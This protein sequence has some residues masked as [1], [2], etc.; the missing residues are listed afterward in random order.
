MYSRWLV[1]QLL[2]SCFDHFLLLYQKDVVKNVAAYKKAV[3]ISCMDPK[4]NRLQRKS[5]IEG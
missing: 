1:V 4:N 3:F 5:E 2:R